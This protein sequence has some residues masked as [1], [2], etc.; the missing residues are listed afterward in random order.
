MQSHTAKVFKA[1]NSQAIRLPK[2]MRLA[3]SSVRL[4]KSGDMIL[5]LDEKAEKRRMARLARLF[6]SCPDFPEVP[7]LDG[8]PAPL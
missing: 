8:S 1:G 5:V 6:G 2:A 3:C 7:A 4:V